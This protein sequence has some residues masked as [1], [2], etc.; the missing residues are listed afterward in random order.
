VLKEIRET[1]NLKREE[2][3][4]NLNERW[5][6]IDERFLAQQKI[7][8]A[9]MMA[10]RKENAE[11]QA[12]VVREQ[13]TFLLRVLDMFADGNI[14]KDELDELRAE[15]KNVLKERLKKIDESKTPHVVAA[16]VEERIEKIVPLPAEDISTAVPQ[17]HAPLPGESAVEIDDEDDELVLPKISEMP[18]H[19]GRR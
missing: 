9:E 6:A 15:Q 18:K 1:M 4:T 11:L 12:S 7:I 5:K 13:H 14:S 3:R 19:R 17:P 10:E 16:K 8:H 2:D